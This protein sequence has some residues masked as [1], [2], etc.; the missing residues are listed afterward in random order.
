LRPDKKVEELGGGI[1]LAHPAKEARVIG[2]KAVKRQV[3][4]DADMYHYNGTNGSWS[5]ANASGPII[6][7][8]IMT[9]QPHA[10]MVGPSQDGGCW[11]KKR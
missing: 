6:G 4:G 8:A 3:L 5:F 7:I 1:S 11:E 2:P 9:P 10:R